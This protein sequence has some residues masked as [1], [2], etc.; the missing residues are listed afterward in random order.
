MRSLAAIK[1]SQV[2]GQAAPL[3]LATTI[4]TT[5]NSDAPWKREQKESLLPRTSEVKASKS[6]ASAS[7]STHVLREV[8]LF[9]QFVE[10]AAQRNAVPSVA[11]CVGGGR[12][13]HRGESQ[14]LRAGLAPA[15]GSWPATL[16]PMASKCCLTLRSSGA[17]TAGRQARALLWFILHRAGL[18][19]CRRR[20]LTSNVRRQPNSLSGT[21]QS[22]TLFGCHPVRGCFL[23][24]RPACG[25]NCTIWSPSVALP[26]STGSSHGSPAVGRG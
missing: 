21:R 22:Q 8:L 24:S 1:S 19:S 23:A 20:P 15:E 14:H 5:L 26:P 6:A 13:R 2:S 18:A 25:S 11:T 12:G 3:H 7:R 10:P 17:P 4:A 16:L 9:I